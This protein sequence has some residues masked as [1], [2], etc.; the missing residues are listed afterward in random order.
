MKENKKHNLGIVLAGGGVK[1]AAHLGVLQALEEH[2]IRPTC[3][4]GTSAGALVGAFYACG[5][6]PKEIL[7][8]VTKNNF[9]KLDA[10]SWTKP[11]MLDSFSLLDAFRPYF[12]NKTFESL[13]IEL[14][15]VAT[16]LV[17][18]VEKV[19][20]SGEI[21]RP[22]LASCAFPFVFAPVEIEDTLYA[23]GGIINN[24]PVEIVTA[25]S[26]NVLGIYVSPLRRITKNQLNNTLDVTDRA[27]RITNRYSSL[28]KLNDCTWIINPVE[29]E[30]YGTFTISKIM[31]IYEL[32]YQ[33]GLEII[34]KIKADLK[35][36]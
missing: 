18:G 8:L 36:D 1:G 10:F 23:D 30:N 7:E 35:L 9:F 6:S 32:G 24:F 34:P 21:Y 11:G 12:E 4:A 25:K 28:K 22:L 29:L 17:R 31:E 2:K 14:H 5:Y 27:Y 33:Y 16:D 13:D 15:I 20:T 3:V 26:E 19:F